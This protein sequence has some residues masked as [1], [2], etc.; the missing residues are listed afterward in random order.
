MSEPMKHFYQ[1]IQ[2]WMD[3]ESTYEEAVRLVPDGGTIVEIGSWRGRSA[4]F[5]AV[6]IA[7][8]GKNIR[9]I[10]VD[11]FSVSLDGNTLAVPCTAD[12]FRANMASGGA[13]H[14][15]EL[16]HMTSAAAAAQLADRT[17]DFVFIDGAHDYES[18]RTDLCSW[19]PKVKVGGVIAGHDYGYAGSAW[20]MVLVATQ[21]VLSWNNVKTRP[22]SVFWYEN[23]VHDFGHW[24]SRPEGGDDYLLHLP[25]VNRPDL[26]RAA[27]NSMTP[28]ERRNAYIIDQSE[29]GFDS[30]GL[31]IGHYR[32]TRKVPFSQMM[33]FSLDMCRIH[34]KKYS[35]F[36]HHDTSCEP[37]TVSRLI[38]RARLSA[39]PW[40]MLL[41][42]DSLSGR[43]WDYLA[44][45]NMATI[46]DVGGWDES[47]MWYVSDSDL[48]HRFQL[49]GKPAIECPDILVKHLLMQTVRSDAKLWE[50]VG[51]EWERARIHYE[52]KWGG[53]FERERHAIPYNGRP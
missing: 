6:E 5:M 51:P 36:M 16:K 41:V 19:L 8:S 48:Y 42:K 47:F 39:G 10:C 22:G 1:S 28:D 18:V 32:G 33:N 49:H 46:R 27:V 21:N 53:G 7:N 31:G 14:L 45:F 2:G 11:S 38:D 52:H 17:C 35:V 30:S 20:P 3:F 24:I 37:G 4:A 9:F 13:S 50:Q 12:E 26:I 34:E 29:D 44:A 15:V 25:H 43:I 23:V 40:S